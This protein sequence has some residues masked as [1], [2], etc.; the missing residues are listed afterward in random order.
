MVELEVMAALAALAAA[1]ATA[2]PEELL[3]F[4]VLVHVNQ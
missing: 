2:A 1:P 4:G 3:V